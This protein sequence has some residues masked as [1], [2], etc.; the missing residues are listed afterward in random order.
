M[1]KHIVMWNLADVAE[2]Y[3]RDQN[4]RKIKSDLE[5][6]PAVIDGILKLEVGININPKGYDLVLYSEFVTA[7]AMAA[8]DTHPAHCKCRDYIRK[9]IT[10]RVVADYEA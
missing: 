1:F 4:A 3:S 6:L 2:G 8:Y 7:E 9:V 5:A 10:E